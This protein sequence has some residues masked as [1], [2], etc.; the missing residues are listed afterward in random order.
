[1][2]RSGRRVSAISWGVVSTRWAWSRPRMSW[3]MA[4]IRSTF[5]ATV[6]VRP[7]FMTAPR[8]VGEEA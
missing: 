5:A 1:M 4:Q 8:R 3:S 2:V 7:P 6:S